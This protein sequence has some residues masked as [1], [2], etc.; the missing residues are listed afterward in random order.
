MQPTRRLP[1]VV[2][3]L[4][5]ALVLAT[6]L[7]SQLAL[8]ADP[9]ASARVA[10]P[11]AAEPEIAPTAF[12]PGKINLTFSRIARGLSDPVFVT[13]SGDSNGRLFVV[14]QTGRI[15]VIRNGVLLSTPFLDLRSKI[16]TG[17][18]RGLLGLAFHPDYSW[19]RKFYVNYTNKSGDTVVAQY[20][21]STS[22]ADR[23]DTTAK[24]VLTIDQPYSNHNGGMLAFGPDRYLYIGD[25]RRR[26]HGRPGQSRPEPQLAPGQ[27]PPDQRRHLEALPRAADEPLRRP[28]RQRP[29]LGVR[30][31]QSVAV[32]VRPGDRRPVDRRRRP[33][34][35]RGGGPVEGAERRPRRELR[36]AAARGQPAA[37]TRRAAA[38]RAARPSRWP[39]TATAS[40]AR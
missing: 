24:T 9:P 30:S 27:D 33:E 16:S 38:R 3:A 15:R 2:R 12:D 11:A 22:S 18:E 31:A 7:S 1:P 40:A 35:L 37:T 4:V 26:Q 19:N 8:A 32:L 34:P 6:V 5:P 20:L 17:G 10:E 28:L 23:A 21:R 25:G 14:E 13:H 36:L 39:R 29:R